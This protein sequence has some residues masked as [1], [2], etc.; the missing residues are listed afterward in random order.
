MCSTNAP[1]VL[2]DFDGK[3]SVVPVGGGG[4][5]TVLVTLLKYYCRNKAIIGIRFIKRPSSL[6][7]LQIPPFSHESVLFG[8]QIGP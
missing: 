7:Y 4:A 6:I 2:Y 5:A 8:L 3:R 1:G